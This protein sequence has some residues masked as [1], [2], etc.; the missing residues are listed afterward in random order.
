MTYFLSYGFK[1]VT[2]ELDIVHLPPLYFW[3]L[4]HIEVH[5]L[6]TP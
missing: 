5:S 6:V 3:S 1:N 4:G 2:E